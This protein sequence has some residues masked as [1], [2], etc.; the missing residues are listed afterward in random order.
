MSL[1]RLEVAGRQVEVLREERQGPPLVLL[2]GAGASARVWAPLIG[3]LGAFDVMAPSLPGRGGSDGEAPASALE[4]AMFVDELLAVFGARGAI[5]LG[6][7]YGG[8]VA[9]ELALLSSRVA[10]LVLVSSG[11]RLR[12]HPMILEAAEKP[13][14]P[15]S[16]AM[17]ARFAFGPGAS[18]LA[19]DDYARALAAVPPAAALADWRACESFDRM[20]ALARIA[21]PVLVVGGE[22]DALTPPKYQ[23]FLAERLPRAQIELVPGQGHM[24]P[25]EAPA[26]L[27]RPMRAWAAAVG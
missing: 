23:R 13:Q 6:H 20:D 7:S 12:V 10:G 8:A 15:E 9:I 14:S 4:A 22:E 19:I 5:V 18:E 17:L 25:F 1:E 3:E 11:A 2:H 16:G 27:A 26:L 24:L 21:A